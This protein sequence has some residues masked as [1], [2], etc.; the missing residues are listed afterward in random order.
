MVFV[1]GYF[2]YKT[3]KLD[4]QTVKTRGIYNLL[5][6]NT[7]ETVEF[8][9]TEEFRC[10][11]LS[12]LKMFWKVMLCKKMYY[13]PAHANLRTIFPIIYCLSVVFR[14][15]IHYFVVGGWL[16]DFLEN[17]PFHR[18]MLAEISGI[19]VETYRLK[20]KLETSYH[21]ENVDIFP[22]FRYFTYD[23]SKFEEGRQSIV[24]EK[25]C[26]RIAFV[27][28]VEQSKGLDTIVQVADI[29]ALKGYSGKITFD[30]YGQKRDG[31]YDGH[32]L[33]NGMF[34]YKGVL[35]PKDVL[36]VLRGYDALIFPTHYEGEGC[37][38]IL[39]E[40]LSV[41]L[42]IV[43][44]DWKYNDEF[45]EN[46]VNGFLC[47]TFNAEAYAKAI[48]TLAENPEMRRFM[49]RQ[50]YVKSQFFSVDRAIL[51]LENIKND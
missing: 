35:Q 24:Y 12:I 41:G 51:L 14:V 49:S 47:E 17:H 23:I 18:R 48:I 32:L 20:R 28:R 40:A 37:P 22:N 43:A 45:V 16:K 44:S 15:K 30:F 11:R 25:G 38:G 50:S 46:E 34:D 7:D 8:Y 10:N 29:L 3:G 39:V 33:G 9:D 26:M 5:K 31:Y 13:L 2:G 19:H 36:E 27:S 21:F 42:P 1:L 6:E 4:G